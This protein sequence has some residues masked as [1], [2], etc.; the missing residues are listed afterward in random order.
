[1]QTN[2][3][4]L[5]KVHVEISYKKAAAKSKYFSYIYYIEPFCSLINKGPGVASETGPLINPQ[6]DDICNPHIN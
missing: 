6:G 4:I 2:T 5:L 3:S 1:M